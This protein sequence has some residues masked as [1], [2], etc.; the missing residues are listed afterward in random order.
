MTPKQIK[1]TE[2]NSLLFTWADESQTELPYKQL[3][4]SCPCANCSGESVILHSYKPQKI[5]LE[6]PGRYD[7]KDIQPV[8]NYA[9]T[10]FWGD[11]HNTGIFSWD[12]LYRLGK[13]AL[14]LEARA[15]QK[16]TDHGHDHDHDHPHHHDH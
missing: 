14:A 4:D 12:L 16:L 7:L 6:T 2:H 11:G 13:L 5:F 15:K 9:I 1:K 10:L 8:G 3:R